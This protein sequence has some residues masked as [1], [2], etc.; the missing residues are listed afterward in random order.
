MI[1]CWG[2]DGKDIFLFE[3]NNGQDSIS[4]FVVAEDKIGVATNLGFADGDE[5]LAATK[6]S[7]TNNGSLVSKITLSPENTI[8]IFHDDDLT[9]DNFDPNIPSK[10]DVNGDG[11]LSG[12]DVFLIAQVS[13]GIIDSFDAFEAI[14]P[15][16]LGDI[17]SDGMISALDASL[18]ARQTSE[19]S[20]DL[21]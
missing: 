5:L 20:S 14:D 17:N 18:V 1:F 3:A 11:S 7:K 10:G 9:A 13:V 15:L 2:G 16:I 19:S 21:I 6:S 8:T 12:L 4:K